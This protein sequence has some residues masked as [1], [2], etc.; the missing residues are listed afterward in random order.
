MTPFRAY[1]HRVDIVVDGGIYNWPI[2]LA[3]IQ[4]QSRSAQILAELEA[5]R[6]VEPAAQAQSENFEEW[7]VTL[8]G[9]TLYDRYIRSYT[10]KQW[11]RPARELPARWAPRRVA[12]RWDND[13]Y[14]FSDPFQG[15][16]AGPNGYTDLIDAL[17][18]NDLT[19]LH[20]GVEVTLDNISRYADD[21]AARAVALTCP[22]DRFCS[23]R[24]GPLEWR[25]ILVRS[26]HI[27]HVQ[28]AQS[29]MVVN[30]PGPEFP[31][32]RV[33]ETKHASGQQCPGTVLG[34]EFTNA[35]ARHYPIETDKN[36]ALNDRYK[37]CVCEALGSDR[38]FF[39]GRLAN[40]TYIDMDD[41]MREAI[42]IS[43]E[44]VASLSTI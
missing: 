2:C 13:P 32:I 37:A 21:T 38:T 14:L 27:P 4:A 44:I 28:Y 12:I 11:G 22:L 8:M 34:F 40:Y 5:R 1:R 7:C 24:F 16:P 29:A 17:L 18:A 19:K 25:G 26:I 42:D 41:C 43:R 33:H 10:E 36:V 9:P 6:L 23:D 39:A 31:F 3:D 20:T 30:Y 15:W 35:P